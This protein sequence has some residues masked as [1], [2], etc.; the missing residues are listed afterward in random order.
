MKR[1][2]DVTRRTPD[3][4][5][6]GR[7]RAK[8]K[9]GKTLREFEKKYQRLLE[10]LGE[11]VYRMSLPDGRCEYFSPSVETVFGYPAKEFLDNPLLIR[12]IIH[13]DSL[14][15]FE[16]KWA[17][18]VKGKVPPTYE[19]KIVD[20][21]GKK[22]WILQ[23][24][25][26]VFD[27]KG[28][29]IAVEG[30]C[31]DIT[32]HKKRE[33]ELESL[34]RYPAENPNP[35]LR[36]D[37]NGVI[38]HA[39]KASDV[40]LEDWGKKMGDPAPKLWCDLVSEVCRSKSSRSVDIECG[41][42]TYLFNVVPGVDSGYVNLYGR[43]ITDRKQVQQALRESEE[44]Y[45]AIVENSAN[46]ITIIQEGSLKYVN[47]AACKRTGW[48][49]EEL[50]SPSF[51]FIE[52]VVSKKFQ[53]LVKANIAKRLRG[54]AIPPY[55]IEMLARDGSKIPVIIHAQNILF[56]GKPADEV[57]LIDITGRKHMEERM[58]KL[59]DCFLS[60]EADPDKNINRIV[61]LCG[62]LLDG[63]CAL[64]NR[65]EQEMLISKGQWKSPPD[66]NPVD[67]PDGHICYDVIRRGS[68]D[69]FVVRNLP[70]TSYAHTDPNVMAYE[71]RTYVGCAVKFGGAY[72][73]SLCVVFQRD[74]YPNEEDKKLMG[75]LAS[76]IGVEEERKR[77]EEALKKSEILLNEVGEVAKVGGWELD[78]ETKNVYWTRETY[79]IHEI[80]EEE[81]FDLKKAVLFFDTP[82]RSTLETALQRG[83]EK[84]EPFDL[85]L[86]FTSAKGRHLWT[87]AMG[88]AV[89]VNGKVVKLMGAFQDITER[90]RME[91]E[92]KR[93]SEHLE[94]LVEERS[95]KLLE[96]EAKF[97]ALYDNAIDGI[98]LTDTDTKK[99]IDGNNAF[100]RML[101]Y[102]L[103]ELKNKTVM[104]IHPK[105]SLPYVLEQFEKLAK[106]KITLTKDI[107]VKRKDGSIFY[108]DISAA[109]MTFGGRVC[110]VGSF[111]DI[112]EHKRME[113]KL[114]KAE[115]FAGIGEAAAMVGHDLRNPLQV[116]V[117][118]LYLAKKATE[119]LSFPYSE[120][121]EKL[122]LKEFFDELTN[123]T[124]YMN[125]IV[126]DLQDYARPLKPELVETNVR[127]LIEGAFS[128][129]N[130]PGNI[131][132]STG[133]VGAVKVAVDPELMRR[134]FTNLILNAFQAMPGGGKLVIRTSETG[135]VVFISFQD[136]GVGIPKENIDRLFTLLYTTK[137]K[138]AGLGLPVC[139][140]LVEAHNGRIMIESEVGKGSTFTVRLPSLR[141]S[142]SKHSL[143][144]E[145]IASSNAN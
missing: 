96:S 16:E 126:S 61:A 37:K 79:Q 41:K 86:P 99:F 88:Q 14:D 3:M 71:L 112:T 36:L 12:K 38:L 122:G 6:V 54:E 32:E 83:M 95:A 69:I 9:T 48:T 130:V 43:D 4:S 22:R 129:I 97:R 109:P 31:A 23:S 85:E 101:G 78:V 90:K 28:N 53:D 89:Q 59:N 100:C 55:E 110:V 68:D 30:L 98:Q 144:S 2:Q 1:K 35:I 72:V 18:L 34:A 143:G 139:K 125:K 136:T 81:K 45:R 44:K 46:L 135:E 15:Y 58:A 17:D 82:G 116:I 141:G 134:V 20:S 40:L 24:N 84:G 50:T 120:I 91:N 26:G 131:E 137:A 29:I 51:N 94:E 39:N 119:R 19:Y 133:A 108:A 42:I 117:N 74:F 128:L 103:E 87:R 114:R 49:F 140:R 7:R 113:E 13:P 64:Y 93:H 21:K 124:E 80:L 5:I 115:R 138:G 33:E 102:S 123:Q 75:I 47:S 52:K 118:R 107:P 56:Q 25:N 76:A 65:L 66:Y 73:G 70:E 57:I 127:Q 92:L 10:G 104:D 77:A 63:T 106:Q 11:A 67:K 142:S 111:R 60:F 145:T 8:E 105:E 62:E 27:R 121:A 132:V